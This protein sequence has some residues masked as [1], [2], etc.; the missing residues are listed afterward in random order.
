MAE[1]SVEW[2]K[3]AGWLARATGADPDLDAAL[4][5][6]FDRPAAPFTASADSARALVA[7]V[8]PGRRLH[9]GFDATGIF[10]YASLGGD[11]E[12]SEAGAPTLPLAILRAMVQAT[13]P[14]P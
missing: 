9:V 4:A 5:A 1:P 13:R 14:H 10:P 8:L 2:E 12:R 3:L 11:G 6:A 7:A